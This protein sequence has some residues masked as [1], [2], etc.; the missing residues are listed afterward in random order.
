MTKNG[1]TRHPGG[2]KRGGGCL[3]K[4]THAIS[5]ANAHPDL[6]LAAFHT[7]PL[8]LAI[9]L[10]KANRFPRHHPKM[11][12]LLNLKTDQQPTR[13]ACTKQRLMPRTADEAG[14]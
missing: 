13:N 8:F 1:Y 12:G 14:R 6:S 3:T 9:R 5:L 2:Q 4:S 7:G 11:A 10:P